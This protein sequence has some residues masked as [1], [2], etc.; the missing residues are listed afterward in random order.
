MNTME[1]ELTEKIYE[2]N[3]ERVRWYLWKNFTWLNQED[4]RDIMQDVW[5]VLSENIDKVGSWAPAAQWGW[6]STVAHNLVVSH[7]RFSTRKD[8]LQEELKD[9]FAEPKHFVSVEDMAIG[10]IMAETL[11]AKLSREDK[12]FILDSSSFSSDGKKQRK[13]NADSCKSYRLRKKLE[14]HMKDGGWDE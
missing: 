4:L 9:K 8:T 10:K 14:K 1:K 12:K 5:I 13:S 11:L 6:L 7:G 3:R 2:E